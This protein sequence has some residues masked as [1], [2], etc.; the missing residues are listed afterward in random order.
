[1]HVFENNCWEMVA[2]AKTGNI[3][4]S[5]NK[6][7]LF[8]TNNTKNVIIA[9]FFVKQARRWNSQTIGQC[10]AGFDCIDSYIETCCIGVWAWKRMR[11]LSSS[12]MMQPTDHTSTADV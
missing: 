7:L 6:K 5:A 9:R 3:I 12:A 2:F 8:C 11:R 1:M 10:E 4:T